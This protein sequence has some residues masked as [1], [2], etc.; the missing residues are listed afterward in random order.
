MT[1]KEAIEALQKMP[2]HELAMM[3]D[4]PHCGH[5]QT[6]TTVGEVVVLRSNEVTP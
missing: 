5:A 6:L 4:C 3:I 2:D 1:V